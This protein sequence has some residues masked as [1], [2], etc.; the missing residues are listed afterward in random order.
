MKIVDFTLKAGNQYY[1]TL[2][3]QEFYIGNR[4]SYLGNKGLMNVRG[5]TEQRYDRN[6][7]RSTFGLWADFIHPTAVVEGGLYHTLNTYDRAR[8][9]FTFLQFAAHVPNGDFVIFLRALLKLPQAEEYFPDLCLENGRICKVTDNGVVPL[10]SDE[11]TERLMDY[12]NPS[13]SEVED[14][15]VI[16]AAKLVHWAQNDIEHRLTQIDTGIQFLKR[17]LA[18]YAKQYRLDGQ[19]DTL[20]LVI[21][22]IRHQGRARSPEII[23][24]LNAQNPL[25]ALLK[26]GESQYTQRVTQLRQEI[27]TLLAEGTLG[28]HRYDA[29]LGDFVPK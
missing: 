26:I 8:L 14:T 7:F 20:C 18:R 2:D 21:S 27:E 29:Q 13:S 25:E 19:D 5:T 28:R 1:G 3:N 22:D 24:A 11:S 23:S 10:E 9:T 15:E 6:Q 17:K 4:V 12:F 16:Q